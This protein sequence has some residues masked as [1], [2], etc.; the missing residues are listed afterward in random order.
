MT[1]I[2]NMCL[3]RCGMLARAIALAPMPSAWAG[4][5]RYVG[6]RGYQVQTW[7]DIERA[8]QDIERL[9]RKEYHYRNAYAATPKASRVAHKQIQPR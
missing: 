9:I 8:R 4:S 5:D 7:Q 6:P 1:K 3:M 2:T